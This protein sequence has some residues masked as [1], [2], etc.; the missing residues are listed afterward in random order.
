[1]QAIPWGPLL[2]FMAGIAL[3]ALYGL[4]ASGHFPA[5]T[6]S[7]EMKSQSGAT[8]LWG[9]LGMAGLATV[10]ALVAAWIALP[11]YAIV[12]GGGAMLLLVPLLLQ[13]FPDRFVDGRVGLLSLAGAAGAVVLV[14]WAAVR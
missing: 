1:M 12:I 9:T 5:A 2:L 14:L 8:I 6:R 4:A 13:A 11:W 10:I 7:P 3:L